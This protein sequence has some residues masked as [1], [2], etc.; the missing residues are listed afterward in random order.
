LTQESKVYAARA[1]H[2][3]RSIGEM[4]GIYLKSFVRNAPLVVFPVQFVLIVY[5]AQPYR[6]V[7]A[8]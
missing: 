4:R 8:D 3:R 1:R 7:I 2:R 5:S 6:A